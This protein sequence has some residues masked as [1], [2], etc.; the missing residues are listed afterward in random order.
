MAD[1]IFARSVTAS[2]SYPSDASHSGSVDKVFRYGWTFKDSPGA[3]QY[4]D[5][6]VLEVDKSYQ[7]NSNDAKVLRIAREWSWIACNS[8][9]VA[10]RDGRYFVVDGQHRVMAAH[11]R[12]DINLLPCLVFET[13]DNVQEAKGFLDANV[14]RKPMTMQERFNALL[15]AED[16]TALK[17]EKYISQTGRSID[18]HGD[19]NSFTAI[20]TLMACIEQDEKALS[21]IWPLMTEICEGRAFHNELL[22]AAFYIECRAEEGYSLA[23]RPWRDKMR[24]VGYNGLIDAIHRA[25]AFYAKGGARVYAEGLVQAINHSMKKNKFQVHWPG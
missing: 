2:E 21:R 23:A 22:Q 18:R 15:K 20:K 19:G 4:L 16:S 1:Q 3:L 9:C 10:N 13:V 25:K 7:R 8:I 17:A 12:S 5:K 11:R 6:R 14:N 24:K